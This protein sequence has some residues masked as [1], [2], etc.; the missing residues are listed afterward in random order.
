MT[1]RRSLRWRS[2]M[3]GGQLRCGSRSVWRRSEL[4]DKNN[5]EVLYFSGRVE[6]RSRTSRK[7]G[8]TS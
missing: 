8:S 2:F 1:P 5:P 4:L 7:P 6:I 3:K